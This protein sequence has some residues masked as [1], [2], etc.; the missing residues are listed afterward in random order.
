MWRLALALSIASLW[1]FPVAGAAEE[2]HS[3]QIV[4]IDPGS[5]TVQIDELAASPSDAPAPVKRTIVLGPDTRIQLMERSQTASGSEWP[6]GFE[7]A[8]CAPADLRAGDFVTATGS[9]QAGRLHA[10]ALDVIR[11]ESSPSASPK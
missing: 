7:A 10:T 1:A 3:G 11:P 5:G 6:G 2:R 4:S 9:E 8:A